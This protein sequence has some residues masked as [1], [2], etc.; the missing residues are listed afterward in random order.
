MPLSHQQMKNFKTNILRDLHSLLVVC[1]CT[2]ISLGHVIISWWDRLLQ[3]RSQKFV[4]G[5]QIFSWANPPISKHDQFGSRQRFPSHLCDSFLR[6]TFIWDMILFV[7]SNH[8]SKLLHVVKTVCVALHL[9]GPVR[10]C[11]IVFVC[12]AYTLPCPP[13]WGLVSN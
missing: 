9:F 13:G 6:K 10:G 12:L 8:V 3:Q 4:Y 5:Q 2:K 1:A 7:Q 11:V